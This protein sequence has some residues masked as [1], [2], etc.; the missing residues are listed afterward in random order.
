MEKMLLTGKSIDELIQMKIQEDYKS[1]QE[2]A[3]KA[4]KIVKIQDISKVP[5]ALI[6][7]KASI[8]KVFNKNTRVESLI[9]GVQAE[10]MLGLQETV[11][12]ALL[13]GKIKAFVASDVYVEFMYARTVV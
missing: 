1:I 12:Q 3:K 6:F 10:A 8:Y 11:R 7:S 4:P 13:N 2:E 9:N 5:P